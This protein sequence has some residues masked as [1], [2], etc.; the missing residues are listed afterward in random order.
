MS[1]RCHRKIWAEDPSCTVLG[2]TYIWDSVYRLGP[3]APQACLGLGAFASVSTHPQHG[4]GRHSH[5]STLL[6]L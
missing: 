3:P 6:F 2:Y 1:L 4:S 5:F